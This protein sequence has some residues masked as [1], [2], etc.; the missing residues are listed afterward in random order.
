[1]SLTLQ[2]EAS[3]KVK[4]AKPKKENIFKK[5]QL[6]LERPKE[7]HNLKRTHWKGKNHINETGRYVKVYIK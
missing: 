3:C 5:K 4:L 1:M 2:W 6:K 7:A